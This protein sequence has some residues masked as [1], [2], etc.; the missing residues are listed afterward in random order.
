MAKSRQSAKPESSKG[1]NSERRNG[2]AWKGDKAPIDRVPGDK[3]YNGPGVKSGVV[4]V[5][6][7]KH[8]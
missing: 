5:Y 8:K 7:G 1:R 4:P 3:G 2:K 6:K